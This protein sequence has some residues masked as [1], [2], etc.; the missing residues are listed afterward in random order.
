[1]DSRWIREA[2]EAVFRPGRYRW[3]HAAALG[4]AANLVSGVGGRRA[5]DRRYYEG[6]RQAPFAPPGWV[7]GPAW[8]INNA[9][10]LWGNLRL[11][12]QPKDTPNRRE[13]LALQGLS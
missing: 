5:E 3:W 7:F 4:V 8:A 11:L 13:L 9:S 2:A 1:M 10:V 12:N 6:M